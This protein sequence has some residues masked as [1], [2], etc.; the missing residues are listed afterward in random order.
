MSLLPSFVN[1]IGVSQ[2]I[3][4]LSHVGCD[5][6][7][8]IHAYAKPTF[9]QHIFAQINHHEEFIRKSTQCTMVVV[10]H[11]MICSYLNY[12]IT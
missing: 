9:T 5:Y 6:G 12:G 3:T 4:Y 11:S 7:Q 10:G 2:S 1:P 8:C